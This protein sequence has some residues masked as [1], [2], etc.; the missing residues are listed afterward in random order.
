[1]FYDR[2]RTADLDDKSN[3]INITKIESTLIIIII[4][5]I[6]SAG[7]I[8]GKYFNRQTFETY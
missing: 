6:I 8:S 7:K 1:V 4:I 2:L 3:T 5:I